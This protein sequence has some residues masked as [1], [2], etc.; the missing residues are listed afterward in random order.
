MNITPT[1]RFQ[2]VIPCES[3]KEAQ[4][5]A[6]LRNFAEERVNAL[7]VVMTIY[8]DKTPLETKSFVFTDEDTE[9]PRFRTSL[10]KQL[11]ELN[12]YPLMDSSFN[13]IEKM[14]SDA[15]FIS[16]T[17]LNHV[18]ET[19]QK[20]QG[21]QGYEENVAH[22][23]AVLKTGNPDSLNK[24]TQQFAPFIQCIG[25]ATSIFEDFN[26]K[27]QIARSQNPFFDSLDE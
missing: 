16:Q 5:Q 3:P 22:A 7:P 9:A 26:L 4:A 8:A 15:W 12:Q 10:L 1:P 20:H 17:F 18:Q 14:Y 24:A 2:A 27:V 21:K 25:S 19:M 13:C 11:K 6:L 23:K